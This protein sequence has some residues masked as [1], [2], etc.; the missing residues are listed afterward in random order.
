MSISKNRISFNTHTVSLFLAILVGAFVRLI[1]PLNGMFPLNDG[2]LFFTMIQDLQ[3]AAGV[4]PN[5]TSYNQAQIPYAYPP[6]AFFLTRLIANLT[7]IP[8]MDLIRLLPPIFSCLTIAAFYRLARR[9]LVTR[10]ITVLATFAF[11]L[12]PTAFDPLIVGAGLTRA[13]GLLFALLT[14]AELHAY[15]SSARQFRWWRLST[16]AGLTLLSHPGMAWFTVY[17]SAIMIIFHSQGNT[18]T[19][20]T[21]TV[22][23][24]GTGLL[25]APWWGTLIAR[26][27]LNALLSPFQTESFS[28]ISLLTPFSMLFTNE[29]LV[30]FLAVFAFLGLIANLKSRSWYLPIWFGMVFM[31]E[32]RLGA[33]YSAVPVALLAGVGMGASLLGSKQAGHHPSRYHLIQRLALGFLC[34]YGLVAAYLAPQYQRLSQEQVDSMDWVQANTTEDATFIVLTGEPS[35]GTDYVSE[36]FPTLTTRI[37]I[38]TPQGYEWLPDQQFNLRASRH[39]ELQTFIDRD[40]EALALWAQ[41]NQIDHS[42]MYIAKTANLSL[43]NWSD[44][45]PNYRVVFENEAAI[46]FEKQP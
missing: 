9:L 42:H 36:W 27:G 20:R 30:D 37:S 21:L 8:L 38:A 7:N 3:N 45:S 34:L 5:I 31:F 10:E 17:S 11:A 46:I 2:G 44:S 25:T 28:A 33:A 14:L 23:A 40:W 41:S 16:L 32:P 1:H 18:K 24:L 6:L 22:S 39:T 29:P 12:L 4:L 19:L 13:L 26:H 35:Y 15:C 43:L